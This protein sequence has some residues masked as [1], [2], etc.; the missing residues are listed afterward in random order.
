MNFNPRTK[1][2]A[3]VIFETFRH[4]VEYWKFWSPLKGIRRVST[5]RRNILGQQREK[6]SFGERSEKI[7]NFLP[8]F[9][10]QKHTFEG[11]EWTSSM[12]ARGVVGIPS[13]DCSWGWYIS[14]LP[15]RGSYS[16]NTGEQSLQSLSPAKKQFFSFWCGMSFFRWPWVPLLEGQAENWGGHNLHLF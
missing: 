1:H 6:N 15:S 11:W 5:L 12:C 14:S 13:K 16:Y 9:G 4:K 7:I 10:A 2:E 3:G 8:S